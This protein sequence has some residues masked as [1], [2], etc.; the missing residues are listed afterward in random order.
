MALLGRLGAHLDLSLEQSRASDDFRL[1]VVAAL[2]RLSA[3]V[4]GMASQI[5]RLEESN[6][7]LS[8]ELALSRDELKQLQRQR[9]VHTKPRALIRGR[10]F[11][12]DERD[13]AP[14]PA[15][16]LVGEAEAEADPWE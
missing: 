10:V 15:P 13:D 2:Q 4:L 12:P 16:L 7:T 11:C 6:R 3:Q 14:A 8:A 1:S 9:H 5:S